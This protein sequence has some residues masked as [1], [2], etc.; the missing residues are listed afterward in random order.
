MTKVTRIDWSADRKRTAVNC[1][2]TDNR[3][4][5]GWAAAG[6]PANRIAAQT[7]VVVMPMRWFDIGGLG[8]VRFRN[9]GAVDLAMPCQL[10]ISDLGRTFGWRA[11]VW[12]VENQLADGERPASSV[13]WRAK[14]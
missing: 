1:D 10:Q 8:P 11:A 5:A 2:E 3:R 9:Q 7:L 12:R 4:A 14:L 6:A 13:A